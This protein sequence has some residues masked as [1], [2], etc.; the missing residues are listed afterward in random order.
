VQVREVEVWQLLDQRL[1][2]V[3]RLPHD[4]LCRRAR[5]APELELLE[6]PS[7]E[8]RRRTRVVAL[9]RDRLGISVRVDVA[10]R[11][12][13]AEAGIVITST[14]ELAPE[15]SRRG[16]PPRGNPFAFSLRVT[17]AGLAICALLLLIFFLFT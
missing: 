14:G 17:L 7:G 3:R 1:D 5:S 6:L 4:E 12:P 2:E 16:E 13:R 8:F 9:P 15:W 10:G 11:R